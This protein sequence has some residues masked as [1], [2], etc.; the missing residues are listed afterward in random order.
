MIVGIDDG[1]ARRDEIGRSRSFGGFSLQ[2][3]GVT[4]Q[5]PSLVQAPPSSTDWGAGA[6]GNVSTLFNGG[7]ILWKRGG[8]GWKSP[9]EVYA[10]T[11]F[12]IEVEPFKQLISLREAH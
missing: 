6:I 9:R 7:E 8:S 11:D 5:T 10:G 4:P 12:R 3:V 1:E 2:A